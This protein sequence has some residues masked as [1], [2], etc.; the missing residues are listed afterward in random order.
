[1]ATYGRIS[2]IYIMEIRIYL[3]FRFTEKV[4]G[5]KTEQSDVATYGGIIHAYI[6]FWVHFEQRTLDTYGGISKLYIIQIL[7]YLFFCFTEIVRSTKTEQSDVATNDRRIH[8]CI[9]FW[10]RVFG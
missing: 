6:F 10:V 1:M 5:T 2:K 3:F 8:V 9:F 7:I 4:R